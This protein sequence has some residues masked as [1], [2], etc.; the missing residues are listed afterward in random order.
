MREEPRVGRREV[1]VLDVRGPQENR[2]WRVKWGGTDGDGK[3]LFPDPEDDDGT[4]WCWQREQNLT[5]ESEPGVRNTVVDLM[6][7]FWRQ[8]AGGIATWVELY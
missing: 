6:R 7:K 2:W 4:G 1:V 3:D 5:F 8:Q